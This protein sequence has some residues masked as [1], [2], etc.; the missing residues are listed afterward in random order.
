MRFKLLVSIA[1][2]GCAAILSPAM[3]AEYALTIKN[4]R[5]QPAEL[6]VPANTPFTLRVN[7]ADATPEEFESKS[8]RVE[9]VIA[10]NSS[11]TFQMR[12]LK[13]GRYTFFGEFNEATAQG[14][15][16]AE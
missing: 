16:I 9:K 5:F 2:L 14:A 7:N 8:L 4:H 1:A 11:G 6:R 3:A 13:P 15:I 12:A 10:G